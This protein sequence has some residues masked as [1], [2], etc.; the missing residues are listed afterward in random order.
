MSIGLSV[1]AGAVQLTSVLLQVA[2]E[3]EERETAV[4]V[5]VGGGARKREN[6]YS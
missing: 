3:R 4:L 6:K 2:G 5:G 1:V